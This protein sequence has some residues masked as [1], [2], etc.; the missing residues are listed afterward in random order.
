MLRAVPTRSIPWLLPGLMLGGAVVGLV[1]GASL[2]ERWQDPALLPLVL[3]L[4]A[5]GT[6]FLSFLKALVV[7]LIVT[8]VVLGVAQLAGLAGFG[9]RAVAVAFYYFATTLA[10]VATG[11]V[12]VN[13]IAPGRNVGELTAHAAPAI[14][15]EGRGPAAAIYDLVVS[16]F[17]PNWI[18]AAAEGNLLGLIVAAVLL[19]AAIASVPRAAEK[20]VPLIDALNEVLLRLVRAAVWAAPIGILGLVADRI[21]VAGGGAAI[22]REL[23]ALGAY[24]L[25]VI[26]GLAIHGGVTLPLVLRFV[27]KRNPLRYANGMSESLVT[28]FGTASSA[29]TLGLT[30]QGVVERNSVSPLAAELVVPLGT[31]VNMNG[32]ALYE[33]VAAVFIAQVVGIELSGVQQIVVLLTATLAAVGAAA[34]PE[35]GLVTLVLV[36]SAVGLPAESVGLILSIDWILDRFRTTV[37]VWG[38]AVGAA[39]LDRWLTGGK[40]AP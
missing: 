23:A 38:D 35:A 31:T 9:R 27:A 40:D 17:P 10:A 25:T 28:A 8:S 3:A 15:L 12:L 1:I 5:C 2:G 4:R 24:S 13:A 36:L 21:G 6:V 29:A 14:A 37:N 7:P 33:A 32:T 16:L 11:L 22:G 19:G 34:I 18:G 20:L 39:V 26:V 30:M